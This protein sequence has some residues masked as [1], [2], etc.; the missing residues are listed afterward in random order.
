MRGL[1][2]LAVAGDL[3]APFVQAIMAIGYRP[4][5]LQGDGKVVDIAIQRTLDAIRD[6]DADVVLASH[7]G[8]FVP[9]LTR[10]GR[11]AAPDRADRLRRVRQRRAAGACP[12]SSCWTWSTTW[13]PSTPGCRGSRIIPI[14][15]FDPL[16]VPLSQWPRSW[17]R[18]PGWARWVDNFATR[19]GGVELAVGGRAAARGA[20]PTGRRSRPRLPFDWG[21][22]GGADPAGLVAA[23]VAPPRAWGVL[24]VRKG[25]FAVARMAGA[26]LV[27]HKVGQRHV[28]GR[29]KA[30]G[31]SQQRFA[32]RRDNQAREAYEAA[33]DHAVRVLGRGPAG[34]VVT[35]GDHA[36]VGEVLADPRLRGLAVVGPWLPVPDP[37][38]RVLDAGARSTPAPSGSRSQR[39][40]TRPAASGAR[41]SDRPG[42]RVRGCTGARGATVAGLLAE[43]ERLAGAEVGR[44]VELDR[45]PRRRRG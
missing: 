23:A 5:P 14:D 1:F 12:A 31:Q 39:D 34:P 22:Y 15:E 16:G 27:E 11:R 13:A 37:R 29:T 21:S 8:D 44:P 32:R 19:H 36:A 6:R 4:I 42:Q 24:L 20:R 26:E 17:S 45:A 10:P 2:F 28:Q 3:P 33:A 30:G 25:G 40:L 7:D 43:G 18:R 41:S 35:G 38:R 9:Q